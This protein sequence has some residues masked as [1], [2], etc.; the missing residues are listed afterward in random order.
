MRYEE[1][2]A[3]FKDSLQVHNYSEKTQGNYL[4]MLKGWKSF[5]AERGKEDLRAVTPED[6]LAYQEALARSSLSKVT[7]ALKL[8]AMKRLFEFLV[9]TNTL[10]LNPAE[11]IRE[12]PRGFRVPQ[13][14]LTQEEMRKL[15]L[16]PNTSLRVGI[17]D[18][19]LLELLYPPA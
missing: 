17:R 3:S 1:A 16:S 5:L 13:P 14:V 9:S 11:G 2:V 8:R 10:L 12:T 6:I 19:A 15:L 4:T 18:R 7:Q